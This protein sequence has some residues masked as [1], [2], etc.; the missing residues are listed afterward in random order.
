MR[1]RGSLVLFSYDL[2][3]R[4]KIA[5]LFL[6]HGARDKAEPMLA[7]IAEEK[8]PTVL[9]VEEFTIVQASIK[10]LGMYSRRN[11]GRAID[12]LLKKLQEKYEE[13]PLIPRNRHL[14]ELAMERAGRG[15]DGKRLAGEAL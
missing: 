6:E 3:D 8:D 1:M 5:R 15:P 2:R 11:D 9:R 10:L 7:N 13:P 12:R 4:Y 14:L